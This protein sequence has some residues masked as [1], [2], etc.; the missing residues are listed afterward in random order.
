MTWDTL[1]LVLAQ[2]ASNDRPVAADDSAPIETIKTPAGKTAGD[3]PPGGGGTPASP[4]LGPLI[5]LLPL[6]LIF[7]MF[8]MGGRKEKKKRAAMLAAM[9]KGDKVQTVGGILGTVVE[10]RDDEIVVKVDE[11][12][13]TRLRFSRTAIQSIL[14]SKNA[15]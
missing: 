8:S 4:G 11:N 9:A 1:T 6:A 10:V 12:A 3:G 7:I 13:N 14:E 2:D 5:W 15:D